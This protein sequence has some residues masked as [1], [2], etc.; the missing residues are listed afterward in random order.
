MKSC[1]TEAPIHES[2]FEAEVGQG[3][4]TGHRSV[5]PA[6][7]TGKGDEHGQQGEASRQAGKLVIGRGFHGY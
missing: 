4:V 6:A 5:S 3:I 7:E 1:P 2:E